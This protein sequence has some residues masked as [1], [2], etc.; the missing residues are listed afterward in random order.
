M[1]GVS[2]K[3]EVTEEVLVSLLIIKLGVVSAVGTEVQL[4]FRVDGW[5][6]KKK[7][8]LNSTQLK[9]KLELSLPKLYQVASEMHLCCI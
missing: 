6:D 7:V 1:G 5:S 4:L 8:I 9:L 2:A 3:L